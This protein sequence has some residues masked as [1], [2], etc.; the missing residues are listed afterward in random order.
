LQCKAGLGRTGTLIGAYLIW[1]YGFT[2]NEA[3]AFMRIVRPGSVVGP[4][5]QYMYL[6]QLEW[7]KWAAVD[8]IRKNQSSNPVASIPLVTPVTPPAEIDDEIDAMQTTP[9]RRTVPLP[10]VTPSRHVAAAAAKATS[11]VPP[12]QPRKTPNAKR[13]AQDSDEEEADDILPALGMAPVVRKI[14]TV[15]SRGITA[16][17]Q[18]PTRVTR[19]TAG[20]AVI[21]NAGTAP[22][23][24]PSPVKTSRQGPNKIPRLATTRTTSA[25]KALAAANA[26]PIPSRPVRNANPPLTSSNPSRLPMLI[27]AKR[28]QHTSS[29]SDV[30]N[31]KR[32][33]TTTADAW[34]ANNVA[35]VVV[36]KSGRPGLRNVRRRRSSFSSADVIA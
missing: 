21:K 12:G 6:K 11:V 28:S 24:P 34:V 3:I 8:E 14:K 35:A 19:S 20:A 5:Q 1:K 17:D 25:A 13:V 16:S 18:R 33:A 4:Q 31:V 29:L 32:T 7:A 10:P 9:T 2:A 15:P 30:A 23:P 22:A 36:P 26:P 27:P